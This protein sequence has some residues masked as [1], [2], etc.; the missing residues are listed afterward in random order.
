MP[1]NTGARKIEEL[2][3]RGVEEVIDRGHLEAALRSGKKLRIK[4]GIDPTSPNIHIGRSIPLFKLRDFQELGHQIVLIIGDF[5][6]IIG[7]TSDKESE[8]PMLTEETVKNNLKNYIKQA[9][10]VVDIKKCEVCYNS[11]WLGKL[12]YHEIGRQ[13]NI[14]SLNEF[15]SRENIRKRLDEGKRISLREVLY[16]LMQ[17]YDSVAVKADVEVGGTDQRFNLLAGREMQ[18]HY[19]QEPQ[20]IMTNPLIEGLDGRKMSSSW[21]N[22]INLFDEP[23]DMFGKVMSLKDELI[24]RYFIL[25]TRISQSEIEEYK[26]ALESGDNPRD[27]KMNLAFEI[28]KQ[29]HGKEAAARAKEEFKNVFQKKELPSDIPGW[30]AS[31]GEYNILDLLFESGL[32]PSKAEAKRMVLGSAVEING[33]T[34]ADWQETIKIEDNMIIQVG[35]RKFIKILVKNHSQ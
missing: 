15:I 22:T 28:V 27:V 4:L 24:I 11:K 20:D 17:G 13:A 3:S 29:Y 2:L 10:K 23:D 32:T 31:K 19:G 30:Q 35:K 34:K 5:T 1:I 21:G 7:D 18:R 14:F 6:G 16:P 9:E 25:T 26:K 12:D 8:R 33:H